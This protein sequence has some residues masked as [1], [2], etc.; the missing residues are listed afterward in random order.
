[1]VES[2]SDGPLT[3]MALKSFI[4]NVGARSPAPGGG[5]VAAA[6]GAMVRS[7]GLRCC[8][9]FVCSGSRIGGDDKE[10][11]HGCFVDDVAPVVV[12]VFMI[13]GWIRGNSDGGLGFGGM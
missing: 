7:L 12:V 5:S 8:W 11:C 3:S 1:M 6:I 2:V 10:P 13:R 9:L 4:L